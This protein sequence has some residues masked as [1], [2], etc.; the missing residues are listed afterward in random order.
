MLED[1]AEAH[2][3]TYKGRPVGSLGDM[4]TFSFYANKVSDRVCFLAVAVPQ[5][6][7]S[8]RSVVAE[9]LACV[10]GCLKESARAK[11]HQSVRASG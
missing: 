9:L 3:A 8:I 11:E 5:H 7:T 2:G 1:A 4:A 10:H 6:A